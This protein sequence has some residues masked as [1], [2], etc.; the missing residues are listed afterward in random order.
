MVAR[1]T[2]PP[3]ATTR[4]SHEATVASGTA[5]RAGRRKAVG[6]ASLNTDVEDLLFVFNK[7][8]MSVDDRY[9]HS[10]SN[11]PNLLRASDFTDR[12][13]EFV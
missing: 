1:S 6:S 13:V 12:T 7:P 9:V 3:P 4:L 2:A 5:E 10:A 11:W 8:N